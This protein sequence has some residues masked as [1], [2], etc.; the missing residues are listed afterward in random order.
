M[1]ARAFLC[2]A[3]VSA[4]VAA[5]A[6]G[7]SVTGADQGYKLAYDTFCRGGRTEQGN[8]LQLLK[9][10][11]IG[12]EAFINARFK[13][14]RDCV[15]PVG[16]GLPEGTLEAVRRLRDP[17]RCSTSPTAC[18]YLMRTRGLIVAHCRSGMR[19]SRCWCGGSAGHPRTPKASVPPLQAAPT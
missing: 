16:G 15:R 19:Y 4:S 2:A 5:I 10:G 8:I 7:P 13:S 6:Q 3:L 11:Q 12:E 9:L 18:G 1:I 14:L 17:K